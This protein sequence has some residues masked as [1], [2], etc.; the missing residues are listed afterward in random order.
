VLAKGNVSVEFEI[1]SVSDSRYQIGYQS[2]NVRSSTTL[3]IIDDDCPVDKT[4]LTG[5]F[6]LTQTNL[7][8]GAATSRIVQIEEDPS[9]PFGLIVTD[10]FVLGSVPTST[11]NLTIVTCPQALV[12]DPEA[13]IGIYLGT[14]NVLM[15]RRDGFFTGQPGPHFEEAGLDLDPDNSL[16]WGSYDDVAGELTIYAWLFVDPLGSFGG[17]EFK[18][19]KIE[20]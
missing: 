17:Y 5:S 15:Q 13:S 6:E 19:T 1:T 20:E 3:T 11:V 2:G 7:G 9:S 16:D 18:L 12:Y 14:N 10:L 8:D 4:M